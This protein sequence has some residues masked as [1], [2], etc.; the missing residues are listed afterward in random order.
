[1]NVT[2]R[3]AHAL[4][5][6]LALLASCVDGPSPKPGTSLPA[7]SGQGA[8]QAER[9]AIEAAIALGSPSA[10]EQAVELAAAATRIPS[11]DAKAYGWVAYEMARLVYPELS[12]ELP[13]STVSPP[14]S[15]LVRAFIDARNGKA[16]SPG[17]GAG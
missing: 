16:V 10:L 8:V 2:R 7:A 13:P 9:A 15:A 6:A 12:G 5:L 11:A 4:P 17:A 3:L 14:D 1:M